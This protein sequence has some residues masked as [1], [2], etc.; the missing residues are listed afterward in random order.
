MK[1]GRPTIYTKALTIEICAA[2]ATTS[3]GLEKICEDHDNFPPWQTIYDWAA[4]R[5]DFAESYARAKEL[6]AQLLAD[7]IIEIAD[8]TEE[9][10][11][12]TDKA[13]GTQ[14]RK[15]RDMIEHR[16]LRVDARKW[17]AA[18]LLPKKYGDRTALTNADGGN[19]GLTIISS[20]PRPPEK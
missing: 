20:V 4:H 1:R 8:T 7:Q 10:M 13:D 14:E 19:I 9:G 16:K 17:V 15:R 2:I 18:K 5:P 12:F 6:Q 11:E 3:D